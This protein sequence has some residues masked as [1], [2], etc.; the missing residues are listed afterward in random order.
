MYTTRYLGRTYRIPQDSISLQPTSPG[1][2]PVSKSTKMLAGRELCGWQ[3]TCNAP[4]AG[5][6][7]NYGAAMALY[8]WTHIPLFED[9]AL[10]YSF[11]GHA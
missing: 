8:F 11:L 1:E 2:A 4:R 6:L 7:V 5:A 9:P 10:G 3:G